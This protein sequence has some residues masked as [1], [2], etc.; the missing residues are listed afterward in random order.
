MFY[1]GQLAWLRSQGFEVHFLC[2]PSDQARE[3]VEAQGATFHAVPME[4]AIAPWADLCSLFQIARLLIRLRPAM[5]NTGTPKAG[6]LVMVAAALVGIRAR[7]YTIHGLRLETFTGLKRRVFMFIE[8]VVCTLA[9]D[10]LCVS[11]SLRARVG[12]LGL[13]PRR[14]SAVAAGGSVNGIDVERFTRSRWAEEGRA[15]RTVHGIAADAPVIGFVGRFVR[16]KGMRELAQVWSF[17]RDRHPTAHLLMVG[18]LDQGDPP[19][20]EDYRRLRADERVHWT[21]FLAEVYH[22]YAAMDL[23]LFPSYREGLSVTLLEAAAMEVPAVA[24]DIPGCCDAVESGQTGVLVPVHD[25]EGFRAAISRYLTDPA[26][27]RRHGQAARVFLIQR[28]SRPQVW[29]ALSAY[30]RGVFER[31]S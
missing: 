30:Y 26:L 16:D 11:H 14:K 15:L 29:Q 17:I 27:R 18:D 3:A 4:R 22:C 19:D 23:L 10:V 6:L 12:E 24:S 5:I 13:C 20:A 8:R 25:V 31:H 9:T 21:G 1:Q 28:F 7:I 2:T